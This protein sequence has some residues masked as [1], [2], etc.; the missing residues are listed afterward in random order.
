[1]LYTG[2]IIMSFTIKCDKCGK[3][4]KLQSEKDFGE[5]TI[6]LVSEISYHGDIHSINIKCECGNEIDEK[7]HY[8]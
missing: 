7:D 6:T 8:R 3:E 1:M 5:G 2:G 4:Q